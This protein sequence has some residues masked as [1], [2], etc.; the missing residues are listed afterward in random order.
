MWPWRQERCLAILSFY[1]EDLKFLSHDL[2]RDLMTIVGYLMTIVKKFIID[3]FK[4]QK[5]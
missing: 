2:W 3:L 1:Y 4:T 5:I